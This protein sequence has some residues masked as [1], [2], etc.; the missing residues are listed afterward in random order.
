MNSES[1]LKYPVVFTG[2]NRMVELEGEAYF[3]VSKDEEHPFVVCTEQLDVTVLGTGFNVM[4]YKRDSRTEVTLVKGKV[5]VKS[6]EINEILTPCR[7]FVMNN[8]NREYE[9]KT[10]N[11]GYLRR[12]ERRST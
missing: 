12:L 1:R 10:V 7:Q 8:E 4:A 3:D 6:G 2:K 9:V 5:D 11:V